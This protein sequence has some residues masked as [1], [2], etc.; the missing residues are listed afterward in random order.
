MNEP[1]LIFLCESTKHP[2]EVLQMNLDSGWIDGLKDFGLKRKPH[3]KL[4]DRELKNLYLL[5][6]NYGKEHRKTCVKSRSRSGTLR[7]VKKCPFTVGISKSGVY[8]HMR[9]DLHGQRS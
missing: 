8:V 3:F 7:E 1:E 9:V 2:V 6:Y 4:L 5:G